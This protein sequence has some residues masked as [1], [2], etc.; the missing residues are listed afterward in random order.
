[1]TRHGGFSAAWSIACAAQD[2]EKAKVSPNCLLQESIEGKRH[3]LRSRA[4][5]K[6]GWRL[7][8]G[9]GWLCPRCFALTK[10]P[11]DLMAG[12]DS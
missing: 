11:A 9:V 6:L 7:V 1:M 10:P 3:S 8:V 2:S 5:R 12:R 4:A